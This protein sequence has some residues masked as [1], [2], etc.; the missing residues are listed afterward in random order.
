MTGDG[1]ELKFW[2]KHFSLFPSVASI[3]QGKLFS[4]QPEPLSCLAP[5]GSH[6]LRWGRRG[7]WI[8]LFSGVPGPSN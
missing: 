6:P 8:V 3:F 5:G 4:Q 1:K 2:P 7:R